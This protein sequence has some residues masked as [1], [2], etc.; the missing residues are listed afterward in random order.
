[1]NWDLLH[2]WLRLPDG[3]WPPD[4]YTLLG[5]ERGQGDAETVE[6]HALER[7]EQIRPYQLM[8]DRE[9]TEGM[10]RLAQAMICLTDP[11][12][13]REYDRSLGLVV[14]EPSP[15]VDTLL[16]PDTDLDADPPLILELVEEPATPETD[17]EVPLL[18]EPADEAS[19]PDPEVVLSLEDEKPA[20]EEP[21]LELALLTEKE[22]REHRRQLYGQLV[23]V[24]RVLRAW[25]Q[26]RPYFADPQHPADRRADTLALTEALIALRQA[27]SAE[28]QL[29]GQPGEPG[30][31]VVLLARQQMSIQTFRALL[32]SQRIA[33]A[34]DWEA[35]RLRLRKHAY[36]LREEARSSLVKGWGR[37]VL[38]PLGRRLVQAPEWSLVVL[39]V[40]ALV[41]AVSRQW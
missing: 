11:S 27:L 33:L 7:M 18:L 26:L 35:G 25:E 40:V 22:N 39:A 24:R 2:R 15:E 29:V 38:R 4:H 36:L 32:P 6:T 31:R 41:I 21:P 17:G 19:T 34:E 10:N 12:A 30:H 9:V 8:H 3:S 14:E 16:A 23:Q 5:L 28:N 20:V 37:R 1:M 13:R